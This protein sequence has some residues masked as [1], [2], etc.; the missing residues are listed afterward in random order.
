VTLL[1]ALVILAAAAALVAC[2]LH[3]ASVRNFAQAGLT[4]LPG[5]LIVVVVWQSASHSPEASSSTART[6]R[7]TLS[8]LHARLGSGDSLFAGGDPLVDH[9]YMPELPA[10]LLTIR[11][12]GD[13]E[14]QLQTQTGEPRVDGNPV[15][16]LVY[17]SQEP[18]D[19][20]DRDPD[21]GGTRFPEH[22]SLCTADSQGQCGHSQHV[23]TWA[24][25]KHIVR[26]AG[27]PPEQME[28]V[29]LYD[30]KSK[31]CA[32]PAADQASRPGP[33]RSIYPLAAFG[34][35]GCHGSQPFTW[36][37]EPAADFL[38]WGGT[39][40]DLLGHPQRE[41]YVLA[42]SRA[43]LL[44]A[45]DGG[46]SQVG[47]KDNRR[48]LKAGSELDA[49]VYFYMLPALPQDKGKEKEPSGRP[50]HGSVQEA[51]IGLPPESGDELDEDS[52]PYSQLKERRSFK[53]SYPQK[54]EPGY[55]LV[56][57]RLD[58]PEQQLKILDAD[59]PQMSLVS[60]EA[61][62]EVLKTG[63]GALG[64][65]LIGS[66]LAS[67][68]PNTIER[69]PSSEQA[70]KLCR[71]AGTDNLLVRS[72]TG[73]GC[74]QLGR[75]F[76]LGDPERMQ[77]RLRIAPVESPPGWISAILLLVTVNFLTRLWL[78]VSPAQSVTL[79]FLEI[80]LALRVLVAFDAAALDWKAEDTVANAW[81]ALLWLPLAFELAPPSPVPIIRALLVRG[82]K[83]FV[84]VAGTLVIV[85]AQGADT[86]PYTWR[87]F[88]NVH[89]GAGRVV[90]VA[91]GLA[92]ITAV[93]TRIDLHAAW[94][95]LNRPAEQMAGSLPTSQQ[96][97]R[98]WV[99]A[100]ALLAF[101]AGLHFLLVVAGI[102]EQLPGGMRVAA[103]VV[104]ALVVAWA[105]L[106]AVVVRQA[107]Q[108]RPGWVLAIA[109]AIVPFLPM[110]SFALAHDNGAYVYFIALAVLMCCQAVPRGWA[111]WS[112]V[113][114]A[115]LAIVC[116][117]FALLGASPV[118][119]SVA[120][121]AVGI[122]VLC[123]F[124]LF[125]LIA[126]TK[127]WTQPQTWRPL[128]LISMILLVVSLH[129]IGSWAK[130][131]T[132][133]PEAGEKMSITALE[134]VKVKTNTIR[135]MNQAVPDLVALLATKDGYEQRD[136]MLEMYAF[137]SPFAGRGWPQKTPPRELLLTHINDTVSAVHLLSPFGR[138]GGIA[139]AIFLLT[140][141]AA[142]F[143]LIDGSPGLRASSAAL[144]A[145]VLAMVSLYMLLDNIGVV[146]FTGRNFYFL[147]V[148]SESD[149]IEGGLLLVIALVGAIPARRVS[150]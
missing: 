76:L 23:L 146:P 132:A 135:L 33:T 124:V 127:G 87:V 72:A 117:L 48:L 13:G 54:Q 121:P 10:H 82:L 21:F 142:I 123:G 143:G 136:A 61:T 99:V 112:T 137:S 110:G 78:R 91:L 125:F 98:P 85:H 83:L 138:V 84:V 70:E 60:L 11:P 50:A 131:N 107:R 96:G 116:M 55:S 106:D 134:G 1:F 104:P 36:G 62:P 6:Y 38:Y 57:L 17:R 65:R 25:E 114:A 113:S 26:H 108:G 74:A 141:V 77:V 97:W 2:T 32:L 111:A 35:E 9:L 148:Q 43:R 5:L 34:R 94:E 46:A 147:S 68:L 28:V 51:G 80:F 12:A 145:L 150:S 120:L 7:V 18:G 15:G 16:L 81:L 49:H 71:R 88:F 3:L 89:D 63:P 47:D 66:P 31:L 37:S 115:S 128:A 95:R 56:D 58:T 130:W 101:V 144:A 30:G 40:K 45:H 109:L 93:L 59:T 20:P 41:L 4:M 19:I 52:E 75:W 102:R 67:S 27:E 126:T 73:A 8:A 100:G 133:D 118:F 119:R 39:K 140:F 14:L 90:L 42:N 53:I 122:L 105:S 24:L 129:V 22:S 139:V 103:V 92:F 79:G 64:F 86:S 149:L 29:Q 69:I 44:V